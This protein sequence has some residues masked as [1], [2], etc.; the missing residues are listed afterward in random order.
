MTKVAYRLSFESKRLTK[1][2]HVFR[3]VKYSKKSLQCFT[4]FFISRLLYFTTLETYREEFLKTFRIRPKIFWYKGDICGNYLAAMCTRGLHW[5][6]SLTFI[7]LLM[8][9][10]HTHLA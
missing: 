7:G 6:V 5:P 1:T 3:L 8:L 4:M 9:F 10:S 2:W